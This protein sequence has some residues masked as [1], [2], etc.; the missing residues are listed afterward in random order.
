MMNSSPRPLK[1]ALDTIKRLRHPVERLM[2]PEQQRDFK[3]LEL[4][5]NKA[6]Q[7]HDEELELARQQAEAKIQ[8]AAAAAEAPPVRRKR[9]WGRISSML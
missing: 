7:A 4:L 3:R 8:A 2:T 5:I 6:Q 9:I 1:I